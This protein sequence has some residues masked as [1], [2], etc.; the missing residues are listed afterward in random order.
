METT[1]K[2]VIHVEFGGKQRP[3]RFGWNAIAYFT[4]ATGIPMANM[5]EVMARMDAQHMTELVW[6]GLKDGA[7]KEGEPFDATWEDVGDWLGDNPGALQ[8]VF[9]H[10]QSSQDSGDDGGKSK[11]GARKR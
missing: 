1:P 6:A 11:K 8:E 4:R 10:F 9:G 3:V 5:E 2:P 7:R